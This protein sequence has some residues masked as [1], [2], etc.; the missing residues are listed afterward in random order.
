LKA[1]VSYESIGR[2]GRL[3]DVRADSRESRTS[4]GLSYFF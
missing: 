2:W 3:G 1:Y 4:A